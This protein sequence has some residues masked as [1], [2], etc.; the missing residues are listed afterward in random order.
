MTH[1][2]QSVWTLSLG[3]LILLPLL[4]LGVAGIVAPDHFVKALPVYRKVKTHLAF[5]RIGFQ[6]TGTLV[7]A[8]AGCCLYALI[9]DL[10]DR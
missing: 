9:E 7:V 2:G 6:F 4:G 5:L 8:F 3:I 1:S 10:L